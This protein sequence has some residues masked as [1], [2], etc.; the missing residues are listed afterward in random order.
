MMLSNSVRDDF[1]SAVE[2][3]HS[4]ASTRNRNSRFIVIGIFGKDKKN[5]LMFKVYHTFFKNCYKLLKT[6]LIITSAF[7]CNLL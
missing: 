7:S 2:A 5:P 3:R 4:K 6:T 1:V